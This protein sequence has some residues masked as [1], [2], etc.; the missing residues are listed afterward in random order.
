MQKTIIKDAVIYNGDCIEILP[1][2]RNEKIAAVITDSPYMINTK[3][4]GS[5]KLSPWGDYING[6]Y[7]YAQWMDQVKKFLLPTGCLW[8]CLNWR[9]MV[10]FQKASCNINWPIESLLVWDKCCI[11]TGSTKGLRPSYELV[12][13]FAKEQFQI[14]NRGIPDIKQVKWSS[15]KPN[16]HPAEKPEELMAFLIE[17]STKPGDVILDPFAGSGTTGAAALKMDRKF[18]GIEQDS[19]WYK[20]TAERLD[21]IG[22]QETLFQ[23]KL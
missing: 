22:R 1:C 13:L 11:G 12:A 23:N 8:A 3:S 21:A 10:T 4:D 17:I 9:S 14:P 6:A 2:L 18:I 19:K 20:Y 7:W 15:T 5:G 16:G